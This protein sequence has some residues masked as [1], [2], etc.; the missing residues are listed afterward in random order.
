MKRT[1]LDTRD[2]GLRSPVSNLTVWWE[3]QT[4]SQVLSTGMEVRLL[5]RGA[6][7]EGT[8]W[9]RMNV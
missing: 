4:H 1:L 5:L 6:H 3:M 7:G 2:T 8:N 9:Y